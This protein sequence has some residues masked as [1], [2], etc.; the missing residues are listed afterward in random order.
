M[1]LLNYLHFFHIKHHEGLDNGLLKVSKLGLLVL[2]LTVFLKYCSLNDVD[3]L[4]I[5]S[6]AMSLYGSGGAG[7]NGDGEWDIE[8]DENC[9]CSGLWAYTLSTYVTGFHLLKMIMVKRMVLLVQ[10]PMFGNDRGMGG[11][12]QEISTLL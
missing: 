8:S 4:G 7:G 5:S 12:S 1:A 3:A 10:N 6:F 2:D 9:P 11:A